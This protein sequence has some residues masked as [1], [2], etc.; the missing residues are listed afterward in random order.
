[1]DVGEEA[2]RAEDQGSVTAKVVAGAEPRGHC[3]ELWD[4]A[5]GGGGVSQAG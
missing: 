5:H 2:I 3:E 4:R 1:M